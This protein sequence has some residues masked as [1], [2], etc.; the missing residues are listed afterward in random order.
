MRRGE[1]PE[2]VKAPVSY[3]PTALGAAVYLNQYQLLPVRRAAECLAALGGIEMSPATVAHA[4]T[5]AAKAL[6]SP[7]QAIRDAVSQAPVAHAD[8]TAIR[9]ASALH[10]LHVMSTPTLT[11]YF[12]HPKRGAEALDAFGLLEDFHGI[13]VHDHWKPYLQYAIEH[14]FCNAHHLRE[15]T[16]V[17]ESGSHQFWAIELIVLLCKAHRLTLQAQA[18]GQARLSDEQIAAF[19]RDYDQT[20]SVGAAFNPEKKPPPGT[21]RRVKQTPAFNLIKRLREHRDETLR[22]LTDPAV[23]FD[24]NLAERDLR[25]P[26]QRQAIS[27][28]FRSE[29][30]SQQFATVR[31]YLST[32]RKQSANI[33]HALVETFRCQPPMPQL[34]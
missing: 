10:W 5:R 24:N 9:V 28:C 16:A 23:P 4:S 22:F 3:G 6:E 11:A 18:Q 8:E 21:Q 31:S 27:G 13:L 30:G 12:A 32:L 34:E 17:A 14:A 19:Q 15:L 1:F 26:K 2:D 20:L 7:V 29:A 25:M 33:F